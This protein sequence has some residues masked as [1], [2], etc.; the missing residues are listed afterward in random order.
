MWPS[1]Q[2]TGFVI[3]WAQVQV[4]HPTA[5]LI[6]SQ[7]PRVQLFSCAVPIEI[8]KHFMYFM[9]LIRNICFPLFLY[10][11]ALGGWQYVLYKL[12]IEFNFYLIFFH[13]DLW[14]VCVVLWP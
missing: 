10:C 4:P 12:S 5:H 8:F 3:W 9:Y 11:K 1:G 14:P 13:L 7:S 2:G 6:C